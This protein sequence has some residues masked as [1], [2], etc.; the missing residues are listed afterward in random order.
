MTSVLRAIDWAVVVEWAAVL[1]T[2]GGA[3]YTRSQ[4]RSAKQALRLSR[5]AKEAAVD[6]AHSARDSAESARVAKD[7]F[8]FRGHP[9]RRS[10]MKSRG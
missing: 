6:Q 7:A 1:A 9:H 8:F 2:L 3:L 10:L 4:A 5:E